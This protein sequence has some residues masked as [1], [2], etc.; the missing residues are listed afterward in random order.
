MNVTELARR[1]KIP[2][3]TLLDKLPEWGFDIGKRAIK[4]DDRQARRILRLWQDGEI[5]LE[6][7]QK[8]KAKMTKV[9]DLLSEG[10]LDVKSLSG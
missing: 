6:A 1:M 8:E 2:T 7:A 4:I 10:V 5:F 9:S 3:N